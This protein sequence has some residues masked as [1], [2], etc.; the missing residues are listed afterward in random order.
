MCYCKKTIT[1]NL[2]YLHF[3]FLEKKLPVLYGRNFQE[4]K[5]VI[6]CPVCFYKTSISTNFHAHMRVHTGEKPFSCRLCPK[7]FA[8]KIHLKRHIDAHS[9]RQLTK[10]I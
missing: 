9:K 5:S 6:C 2:I 3:A 7:T 4:G 1:F 10:I 8:Q